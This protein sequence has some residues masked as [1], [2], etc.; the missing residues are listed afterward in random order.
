MSRLVLLESPYA[1]QDAGTH[2]HPAFPGSSY[3]FIV[4]ARRC[5]RDSVL[6]GEAPFPSHLIYT[7][8]GILDDTSAGERQLGIDAGTAWLGKAEA[9]VVYTDYGVSRGMQHR[10]EHARGMGLPIETREIGK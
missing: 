3:Q 9:V 8:S 5:T 7:Q 4:Y 2:E 1:K 6:R 10:I